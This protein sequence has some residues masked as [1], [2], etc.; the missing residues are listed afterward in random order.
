MRTDFCGDAFGVALPADSS[1]LHQLAQAFLIF[2]GQSLELIASR[3]E[4]DAGDGCLHF[5]SSM[6]F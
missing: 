4:T 2:G 1:H 3:N 6:L 5:F